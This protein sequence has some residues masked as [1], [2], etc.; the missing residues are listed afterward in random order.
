MFRTMTR[1]SVAFEA[2]GKW[3][4]GGAG[5]RGRFENRNHKPFIM[6]E[7]PPLAKEKRRVKRRRFDSFFSLGGPRGGDVHACLGFS[8]P[9]DATTDFSQHRLSSTLPDPALP[10]GGGPYDCES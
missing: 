9:I 7:K 2:G 8:T 1:D 10:D 3:C 6:D 5:E 4:G